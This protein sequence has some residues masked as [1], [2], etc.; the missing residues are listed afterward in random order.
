MGE[1]IKKLTFGNFFTK[2]IVHPRNEK[3]TDRDRNVATAASVALGFALL[4]SVHLAVKIG[5][6]GVWLFKWF[7]E[8]DTEGGHE[9]EVQALAQQ[10]L[11][12]NKSDGEKVAVPAA[13]QPP[14]KTPREVLNDFAKEF[15]PKAQAL[16]G[17]FA[18]K[19]LPNLGNTC[20]MNAALQN[21]EALI[22]S[23]PAG[24]VL[25]K[26]DLSF[27]A[28]ETYE[29]IEKR[30]MHTF[31]PI[32]EPQISQEVVRSK[33]Q[34][35][36][37]YEAFKK[38]TLENRLAMVMP[39]YRLKLEIKWSLLVLLQVKQFGTEAQLKDAIEA[40][41]DHFFDKEDNDF[42]KFNRMR[43][44]DTGDYMRLIIEKLGLMFPIVEES[45]KRGQKVPDLKRDMNPYLDIKPLF[46]PEKPEFF[47]DALDKKFF[48]ER[49][50]D[51]LFS[52][53]KLAG[54]P[55]A[56]MVLR[57]ERNFTAPV[58]K[59]MHKVEL[60]PQL[61]NGNV[62]LMPVKK[63]IPLPLANEQRKNISVLQ[64]DDINIDDI[65]L[66]KFYEGEK[67]AHYKIVA[68][69][70]HLGASQEGG[71]YI[72][73][74]RSGDDWYVLDDNAAPVKIERERVPFGAATMLTMV[75]VEAPAVQPA[76]PAVAPAKPKPVVAAKKAPPTPPKKPAP[77]PVPVKE[78]PAIEG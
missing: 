18:V 59:V 16:E 13:P 29:G 32:A 57:M 58:E 67:S 14:K 39:E 42:V 7:N 24:A 72:S 52:R 38:K 30:L 69:N 5:R 10:I 1:G 65:D 43:Q 71:H 20:Y 75:R 6:I 78:E 2:Y 34:D 12:V 51:N 48:Y 68:V 37:A 61:V 35:D 40:H 60:M 23:Q 19:G 26:Q 21:I 76:R 47:K 54:E 8:E 22:L 36:A 9:D 33:N 56:N 25:L 55:P 64:F 46:M 3:L 27:A 45:Q 44:L 62:V 31:A 63:I 66:S 77:A 17:P 73:Y 53:I 50:D 15:A 41:R 11:Q 28:D 49:V 70:L 4:G 74:V